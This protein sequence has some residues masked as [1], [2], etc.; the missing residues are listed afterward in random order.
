MSKPYIQYKK[1]RKNILPAIKL[2]EYILPAVILLTA[3]LCLYQSWYIFYRSGYFRLKKINL[4]GNSVLQTEDILQLCGLSHNILVFH[5]DYQNVSEKIRQGNPWIK[6]VQII[7][8]APDEI[9]I[10]LTERVALF[11]LQSDTDL[12]GLSDDGFLLPV[13]KELEANIPKVLQVQ[14]EKEELKNRKILPEKRKKIEEWLQILANSSFNNY[15][16]LFLPNIGHL[17]LELAQTK[18]FLEKPD[19]FRKHEKKM[20]SFIQKMRI[21]NRKIDYIDARFDSLVVRLI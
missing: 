4:S 17:K 7:Q 20:L 14:L 10:Q 5:I 21:E 6:D 1:N 2:Q 15:D 8:S 13:P 3:V 16:S 19:F 12:F 18:I 9:H 11:Y